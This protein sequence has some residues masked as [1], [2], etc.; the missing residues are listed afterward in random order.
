[1]KFSVNGEETSFVGWFASCFLGGLFVIG[2][3]YL[4][5]FVGSELFGQ[6]SENTPPEIRRK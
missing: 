4:S 2:I 6:I 5:F 1:M 3:F